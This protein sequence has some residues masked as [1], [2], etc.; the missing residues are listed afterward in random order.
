MENQKL[1]SLH[2]IQTGK[3]PE[4]WKER[5]IIK[6][7]DE[8]DIDISLQERDMILSSLNKGQ[9][10]IQI[11][12]YTLMLN[13]IKSID[14]KWGPKNTPPRPKPQYRYEEK[15]EKILQITT[16]EAEIEE[17]ISLFDLPPHRY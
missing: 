10:F 11:G 17:W 7:I 5:F 4:K 8:E 14:P 6:R 9:R 3:I 16:N 13:G 12:K 1:T 2:Q 15:G